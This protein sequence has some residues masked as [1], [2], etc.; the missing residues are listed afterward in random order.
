MVVWELFSYV[1]LFTLQSL[2]I[3]SSAN[4]LCLGASYSLALLDYS[5]T[6]TT[7]KLPPMMS[8]AFL[9]FFDPFILQHDFVHF[10]I[11]IRRGSFK[12]SSLTTLI[13]D[14]VLLF[15]RIPFLKKS[16]YVAF[17]ERFSLISEGS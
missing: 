4:F 3:F 6:A 15:L 7:E 10:F 5:H 11:R 12:S 9:N 2:S 1:C 17:Y 16:F 8:P 14:E 13:F